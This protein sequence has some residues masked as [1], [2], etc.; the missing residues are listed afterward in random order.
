[1]LFC[2]T[3]GM[4]ARTHDLA[5]I[6]L[7]GVV[8]LSQPPRTLSLA[9]AMI[10]LLANQLGGIVPDIDQPTAP[11]W[12][13]L[14]IGHFF[15][16]LTN[17][18]LGGHRFIT[19]SIFGMAAIGLAAKAALAFVSPIIPSIDI[20]LVWWAFMIGLFS[21]LV[22]DSLTKE[23]VPWL[24]PVP[25]KFGFPPIK[26]LRLTTGKIGEKLLFCALILFDVV[27]VWMHYQVLIAMLHTAH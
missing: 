24:L 4:T 13:N 7:L 10:A 22:M 9:T 16:R 21:H 19:H 20:G 6:T 2:Y 8:V 11:F 17:D 1:M 15:G 14:P 3:V 27:Y 5:A 12:R 25:V 23:G 18:L 26:R